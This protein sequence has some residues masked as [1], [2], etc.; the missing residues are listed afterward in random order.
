MTSQRTLTRSTTDK[1][2]AGVAGGL[3]RYFDIDPLLFRIG[4]AVTTLATGA[5]LLAYL[6]LWIFVP[7]GDRPAT[8]PPPAPAM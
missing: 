4:F 1:H 6:L 3:A 2:V 5:G 7:A 8:V